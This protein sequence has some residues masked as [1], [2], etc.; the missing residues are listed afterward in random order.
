MIMSWKTEL[1]V[2]LS[3]DALVLI[4]FRGGGGDRKVSFGLWFLYGTL[5]RCMARGININLFVIN[6]NSGYAM[7]FAEHTGRPHLGLD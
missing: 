3:D 2:D 6:A 7:Y 5:E 1:E 4:L